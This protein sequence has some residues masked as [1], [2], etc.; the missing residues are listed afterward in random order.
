MFEVTQGLQLTF[1]KSSISTTLLAAWILAVLSTLIVKDIF[2]VGVI[3]GDD[4]GFVSQLTSRRTKA[5]K[6]DKKRSK[7]DDDV[8]SSHIM[9]GKYA[10]LQEFNDEESEAWLYFIR[11]KGNEDNLKYLEF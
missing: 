4:G 1:A 3:S 10:I 2:P 11:W 9:E 6:K 5:V 7:K 8:K